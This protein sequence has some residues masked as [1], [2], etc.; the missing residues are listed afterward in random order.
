MGNLKGAGRIKNFATV[1]GGFEYNNAFMK[2][3]DQSMQF[4]PRENGYEFDSSIMA[5]GSGDFLN[6]YMAPDLAYDNPTIGQTSYMRNNLWYDNKSYG[7]GF[8]QIRNAFKGTTY[9]N[10]NYFGGMGKDKRAHNAYQQLYYADS[11]KRDYV[12]G[13]I[14][15]ANVQATIYEQNNV[16]DTTFV[17]PLGSFLVP[18]TGLTNSVS[19]TTYVSALQPL[20]FNNYFDHM[21]DTAY[22]TVERWM[23]LQGTKW[24]RTPLNGCC[25]YRDSRFGTSFEKI[26]IDNRTQSTTSITPTVGAAVSATV[27]TGR[28]YNTGEKLWFYR[29]VL[30]NTTNNFLGTITGYNTGTGLVNMTVDSVTGATTAYA[31]WKVQHEIQYIQLRRTYMKDAIVRHEGKFYISLQ[32]NNTSHMPP[33]G[34]DSWWKLLVFSNGRLFPPDD[35]T[36][37]SGSFYRNLGMGLTYPAAAPAVKRFQRVIKIGNRTFKPKYRSGS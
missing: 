21:V 22:S 29:D 31:N 33:T 4:Q 3:Q 36:L 26:M 34:G 17:N 30:D 12:V 32:D 13:T 20:V 28:R 2:W 7:A 37:P 35:L 27:A 10:G 15:D 19:G 18:T 24:I 5:G 6:W 11:V 14:S 16:V 1:G 23:D 8:L 25:G 9:F